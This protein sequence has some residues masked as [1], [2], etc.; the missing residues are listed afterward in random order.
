MLTD[1]RGS[2]LRL[3]Y[4]TLFIL[5][6]FFPP[7]VATPRN[8]PGPLRYRGF[9]IT[10]PLHSVGLLW[11]GDQPVAQTRRSTQWRKISKPLAGFESAIQARDRLQFHTLD[12]EATVIGFISKVYNFYL[13]NVSIV[14]DTRGGLP[15][16]R[17][18]TSDSGKTSLVHCVQTGFAALAACTQSVLRAV[19]MY[20]K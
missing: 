9:T 8:G 10:L 19:S 6:R 14:S 12:G 18:L 7:H 16:I 17:G 1:K 2:L 4:I 20:V 3:W 5:V 15:R 13:T 11:T